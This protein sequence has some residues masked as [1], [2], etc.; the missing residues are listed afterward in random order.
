MPTV[1]PTL[2]DPGLS[3]DRSD[4]TTFTARSI[5]RDDFIKNTEIPERRLSLANAYSNSVDAYNNAAVS[6]TQAAAA[7]ASAAGAASSVGASVWVSG[8][9]YAQYARVISPLDFLIYRRKFA[10]S[11]TTDP[12][13]DPTNWAIPV[14]VPAYAVFSSAT[15][16]NQTFGAYN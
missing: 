9:V 5:A 7:A 4:R 15:Q 12:K 1:P 16:I 10:G 3:P 11:S 8:T 2:T 6:V 13:L 14:I